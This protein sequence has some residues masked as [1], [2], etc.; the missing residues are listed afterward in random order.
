MRGKERED[1]LCAVRD[2]LLASWS[3]PVY[4]ALVFQSVCESLEDALRSADQTSDAMLGILRTS[5]WDDGTYLAPLLGKFYKI[6]LQALA[7][8]HGWAKTQIDAAGGDASKL[9][10]LARNLRNTC[11]HCKKEIAEMVLDRS[12][13]DIF[14]SGARRG[15]DLFSDKFRQL[16]EAT[17]AAA[18]SVIASMCASG[19]KER[20]KGVPALYRMT[21]KPAPTV[22]SKY[23][24]SLFEPLDLF[25]ETEKLGADFASVVIADISSVYLEAVK[26]TL[27][28]VR[29][30]EAS[31][32]RLKRSRATSG[33]VKCLTGIR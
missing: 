9:M 5:L 7:R 30:T 15:L 31:L 3:L 21:N 6:T 13:D 16:R 28:V 26:E 2:E 32:A 23:T 25:L 12:Q 8:Y 4:A 27:E 11:M 19:L 22:P 17:L 18:Q 1:S 33:P 10:A 24:A 14:C 20:V 29:K